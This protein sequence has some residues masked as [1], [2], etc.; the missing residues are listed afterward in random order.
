MS[1]GTNWTSRGKKLTLR[2]IGIVDT[3][4]ETPGDTLHTVGNAGI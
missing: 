2:L 4:A 3:E 1:W